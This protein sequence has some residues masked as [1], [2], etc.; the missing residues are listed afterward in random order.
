MG[1]TYIRFAFVFASSN[2]ELGFA[3]YRMMVKFNYDCFR[4]APTPDDY[5]SRFSSD[6]RF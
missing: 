2:P 3:E 6:F 1:K 4:I 5:R